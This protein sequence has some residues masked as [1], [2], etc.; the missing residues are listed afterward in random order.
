MVL[1]G[2]LGS[3]GLTE[4]L[5]IGPN[6]PRMGRP[7]SAPANA[8]PPVPR[9]EIPAFRAASGDPA[10]W[11]KPADKALTFRTTGQAQDVSLI[12]LNR[13]FGKRHSVYWQVG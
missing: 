10:L 12:P 1:A 4:R 9:I 7:R 2:D 13:I 3:E 6:A 11:I 5:I 8:P